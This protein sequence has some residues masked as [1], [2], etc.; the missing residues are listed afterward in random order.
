MP[1]LTHKIFILGSGTWGTAIA[2]LLASKG[3]EVYLWSKFQNEIDL[4]KSSKQHKN[5]PGTILNDSIIFTTSLN[6]LE[7]AEF[8]VFATPSIFIKETAILAKPHLH[9]DQIII[10]VAKGIEK[11]S[12]Y[13]MSELIK[14]VLG[15]E[16]NVVALSGPTHAEEVAKLMPTLIVSACENDE[17][18]KRVQEVFSTRYFRV[19]TNNDIVGVELSGAL[20]N[21]VALAAG[22]SYGLGYGDNAKAAIVTR[23]LAE[24][25]RLGKAMGC[26]PYTF[27]GLTGIGDIVVTATSMHSRNNK[28][29]M[30]IGQGLEIDEAIAKVGMVVEGINALDAAIQLEEKYKVELPIAHAVYDIVKK[31]RNVKQTV[32]DL[33][34]RSLKEE[35]N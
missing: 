29:G 15:N 20:K 22:I 23:G 1:N 12:L 3:D 24:I 6:E 8:V 13:T 27:S 7:N 28:C 35:G 19:Y 26:N 11:D 4:L 32:E 30:Y 25:T 10:D 14:S 9:K 18:A 5:L 17:V 16:F 2:N 34:A 33:F 21:I 31:H